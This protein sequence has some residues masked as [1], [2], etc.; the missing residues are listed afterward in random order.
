MIEYTLIDN[1][2]N[3]LGNICFDLFMFFRDFTFD[4]YREMITR[5]IIYAGTEEEIDRIIAMINQR[6]GM[7]Q[8][9]K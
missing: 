9:D 5:D 2:K 8:V 6:D 4:E 7:S 1:V 3:W